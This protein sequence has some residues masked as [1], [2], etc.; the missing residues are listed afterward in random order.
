MG[1]SPQDRRRRYINK[2]HSG[3]LALESSVVGIDLEVGVADA[4]GHALVV[5]N[6][7]LHPIHQ[8][9]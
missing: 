7:D 8:W 4:H 6:N 9:P 3:D 5:R 1:L 2:A